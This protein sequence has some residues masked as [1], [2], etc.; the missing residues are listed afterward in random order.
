LPQI[1]Q[2]YVAA[3]ARVIEAAVG[4]FAYQAFLLHGLI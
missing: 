3:G 1:L 4:I 2:S